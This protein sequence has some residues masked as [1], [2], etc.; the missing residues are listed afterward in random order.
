MLRCIV[1]MDNQT[2]VQITLVPS[3]TSLFETKQFCIYSVVV[4]RIN[5]CN[6]LLLTLL[7]LISRD[8]C[9]RDLVQKQTFGPIHSTK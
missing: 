1:C 6:I 7:L 8:G 4:R 2:V 9:K 3:Q 5:Y